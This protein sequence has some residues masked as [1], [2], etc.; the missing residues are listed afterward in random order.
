M[1]TYTTLKIEFTDEEIEKLFRQEF[2]WDYVNNWFNH[3][4]W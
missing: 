3:L 1:E 4:L 2:S